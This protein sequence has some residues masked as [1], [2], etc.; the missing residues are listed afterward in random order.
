[1][2]DSLFDILQSKDFDEP[3][4]AAA[5]K[6]Y[7]LDKYKLAVEVTVREKDIIVASQ[8]AAFTN[9]LRMQTRQ[10]QRAAETDKRLIF[11]IA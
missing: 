8:G 5:I 10:I 1:M 3:P 11:R 7:V 2:A 6:R 4:E 9:T